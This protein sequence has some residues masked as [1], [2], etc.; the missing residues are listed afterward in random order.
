MNAPDASP[1]SVP[2][3]YTV[4]DIHYLA[5]KGIIAQDARFELIDGEIKDMSPKG[6][7]HEEVRRLINRW[8]KTLPADFDHLAETTLYLDDATF[9][10]PDYVIF[11]TKTA[12]KGMK[13]A[14]ILL[15]I[16]VAD[17]SW[18]Y[19]SGTKAARYS[20]HGV[21]EYWII[22]AA[23]ARVRVYRGPTATGWT[24][25]RDIPIDESP[26]PI[27]APHAPLKLK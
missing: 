22:R 20:A 14:D 21:Q 23:T 8:I 15:A 18:D 26:A 13:A 9:V 12:I 17:T 7:L 2:R 10:E 5:D 4:A 11:D 19:D 24:D 16:E 3:R 1:S 6:P 27:C 25:T